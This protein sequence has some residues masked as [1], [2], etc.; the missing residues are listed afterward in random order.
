KKKAVAIVNGKTL[1][2]GDRIEGAFL[3]KIEQESVTFE[4]G[5]VKKELFLLR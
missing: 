4:K 2:L 1:Q 5:S 3:L